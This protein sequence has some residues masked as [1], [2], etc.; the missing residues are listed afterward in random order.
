VIRVE[1]GGERVPGQAGYL[2]IVARR[3]PDLLPVVQ[4]HFRRDPGVEVILDRRR[5]LREDSAD[6]GPVAP[7]RRRYDYWADVRFHDVV[8][9]VRADRPRDVPRREAGEDVMVPSEDEERLR[10]WIDEGQFI[11][12]H[13]I[14]GALQAWERQRSRAEAAEE[15]S[16]KLGDEVGRL[17]ED[18]E[19]MRREWAEVRLGL[20]TILGH[21]AQAMA[22]LAEV[23][24]RLA[25]GR[26]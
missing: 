25:S 2:I 26:R 21:L 13:V 23:A 8:L 22:P 9:A 3:R 15:E 1:S 16:R 20:Q 24:E 14:P 10:R 4:R 12:G 7:G 11:L 6:D 5:E 19:S 17:R 18:V